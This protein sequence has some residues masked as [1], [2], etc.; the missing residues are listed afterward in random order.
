MLYF[1]NSFKEYLKQIGICLLLLSVVALYS[2][3]PALAQEA[4]ASETR[5]Q[6]LSEVRSNRLSP[7]TANTSVESPATEE[8]ATE[9]QPA[10]ELPVQTPV[11]DSQE[12]ESQ[13]PEAEPDTSL[14]EEKK[15]KPEE[16]EELPALESSSSE[17]YTGDQEPTK[18]TFNLIVDQSTGALVYDYPIDLP[19]GRSGLNPDL[20]LTYNSQDNEKFNIIGQGWTVNIPYIQRIPRKGVDNLY[21]ET[22]NQFFYSSLSGELATTTATTTYEAKIDNGSFYQYEFVDEEKW[23]VTDKNGTIFKFGY[24][25]S[26]QQYYST[27]TYTWLLEEVRDTNDNYIRYEYYHDSGQVYPDKIHYTGHGSTDGIFEVEFLRESRSDIFKRYDMG[28]R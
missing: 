20:A 4:A 15:T 27:S 6:I 1:Y 2:P 22:G 11:V 19:P 9:E 21:N 24:S 10:T 13:T 7:D 17:D 16:P 28:L 26:S 14:E 5:D 23:Q 18:N 25:T 8:V 3:L 12:T